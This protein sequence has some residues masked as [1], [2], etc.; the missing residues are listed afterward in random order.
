MT[1]VADIKKRVTLRTAKP[2][3]RF[4]VQIVAEGK[5]I[6]TRLEPVSEQRPAK[7]R[8]K[9]QGRYSVGMLGHTINEHALRDAL[10]EFP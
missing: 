4:D 5:F 3:E 10:N 9:K 6:L 8:I 1:V 7:V 2:G